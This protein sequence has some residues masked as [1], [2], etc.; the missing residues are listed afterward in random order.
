M[1][2][3]SF[4]AMA[5]GVSGGATMPNQLAAMNSGKNSAMAGTSG[6]SGMRGGA[7]I[8]SALSLPSLT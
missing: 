3:D 1:A 8:A 2:C 4:A 7:P 5:G 6:S